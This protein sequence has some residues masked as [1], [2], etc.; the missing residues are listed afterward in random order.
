VNL[1]EFN[2]YLEVTAITRR[3][4]PILTSIISQ[5]T[6]SESSLI[7][8]VAFEPMFLHHLRETLG[9]KGIKRVIMHEPLTNLRKVVVIVVDKGIPS[10][11]LWRA[12]YGAAVFQRSSGKFVIAVDE[13]IDPD[14]ADALLWAMSYRMQPERDMQVLPHRDPGHG[15][16]TEDRA[17]EASVLMDA[18]LK[19]AFPPISLPK[20]EYMERA[21][22][23]WDELGLPPLRPEP[24][25]HGYS[26]GD[27][28][29]KFEA[30]ARAAVRGDYFQTADRLA[31]DRRSDVDMN[32]EIR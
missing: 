10:V 20:R 26:L 16:R 1:Q 12:L 5:V 8:R 17:T 4:D 11:E 21:R 25:W 14:N 15:P 24:P 13:D 3:R 29:D 28:P 7:K 30:D 9:I 22:V 32:T 6:P 2:A 19:N 27:W 31:G 18:T 23:I